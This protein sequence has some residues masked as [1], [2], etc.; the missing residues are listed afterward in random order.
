M[1]ST[2]VWARFL[3]EG[4]EA[5]WRGTSAWLALLQAGIET[6]GLGQ[7]PSGADCTAH[8]MTAPRYPTGVCGTDFLLRVAQAG[9]ILAGGLHPAIKSE[10]FRIGHMGSVSMGDILSTLGAVESALAAC[11]HRFERGA[12]VAAAMVAYSGED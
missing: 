3:A 4:M 2:S 9:V 6:L 10:Y 1:G 7:V 11:G 12:G 5:R 8:T